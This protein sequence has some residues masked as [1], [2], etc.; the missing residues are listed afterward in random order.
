MS[1]Y[2][3]LI[4][5]T[6]GLNIFQIQTKL[7]KMKRDHDI[8][9]CVIDYL[10]LIESLDHRGDNRQ[11]QIA[12][13]S[14][15]L[16]KIARE[17]KIPIIALSQ[18]SRSV[19]QRENKM[20]IMSDLRESGAIEQDA[21]I[22]MFLYREEYYKKLE[23]P[24]DLTVADENTMKKLLILLMLATISAS[25]TLSVVAC[26]GLVTKDV[27]IHVSDGDKIDDFKFDTMVNN[28]ISFIALNVMNLLTLTD[29][30]YV[31]NEAHFEELKNNEENVINKLVTKKD[32]KIFNDFLRDYNSPNDYYF[33]NISFDTKNMKKLDVKENKIQFINRVKT[34]ENDKETTTETL[35]DGGSTMVVAAQSAGYKDGDGNYDIPEISAQSV[36]ETLNY[37]TANDEQK[38][39]F[40]KKLS[41]ITDTTNFYTIIKEGSNGVKNTTIASTVLELDAKEDIKVG[42]DFEAKNQTYNIQISFGGLHMLLQANTGPDVIVNKEPS[43]NTTADHKIITAYYPLGYTFKS[44][45]G[46]RKM[47]KYSI[48][49]KSNKY[50]VVRRQDKKVVGIFFQKVFAH[51]FLLL[52]EKRAKMKNE[53]NNS[54][55]KKDNLSYR[56]QRRR[57]EEEPE[58]ETFEPSIISRKNKSIK[59]KEIDLSLA[60][61][62]FISDTT[63]T[64]DN[65]QDP[66]FNL[67]QADGIAFSNSNP[68]IKFPPSLK[69]IFK[70]LEKD[71]GIVKNNGDLEGWSNNMAIAASALLGVVAFMYIIYNS[72]SY[73]ILKEKYHGIRFTT[74]NIAYITMFTAVS[75]SVTVVISLTIPV[76]VFPPIRVAF[77]G[78]MIKITGLIF[79]PIV[80][81]IVGITTEILVMLFVPSFIHPAFTI[82][83]VAY[84]FIAG[85][86]SSF[87]RAGK[88]KE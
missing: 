19:E 50:Y 42:F 75:V 55:E 26:G 25:A 11:N 46:K 69:N 10:Q 65:G 61:N 82:C 86:G 20:P 4:D 64:I 17:L 32:K 21:D 54:L 80:G 14:R 84:G 48:L 87:T 41:T 28:G 29:N 45:L 72:L 73:A 5:D 57:F 62:N 22:I 71:L 43:G 3:L 47:G 83:A 53:L 85:V 35:M 78:V 60:Y 31:G 37:T 39:D 18:L 15:Q 74:K 67:G 63:S 76:T 2:N 24:T 23:E 8:Q 12:Q 66:Y 27:N 13:I 9:I 34:K 36:V 44:I 6:P 16:K 58:M 38:K 77:E 70:E 1:E 33:N 81:L 79:G 49:F 51:H 52:L 56:S 40:D 7:R 68:N 59:D 88:G 30:G